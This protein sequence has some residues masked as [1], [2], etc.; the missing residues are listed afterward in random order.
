MK[1]ELFV[2]SDQIR[3]DQCLKYSQHS[4]LLVF[5]PRKKKLKSGHTSHH[6]PSGKGGASLI[7]R[8][9]WLCVTCIYGNVGGSTQAKTPWRM[10]MAGVSRMQLF[11]RLVWRLTSKSISFFRESCWFWNA[12]DRA[13]ITFI[14]SF[15]LCLLL[16]SLGLLLNRI[17]F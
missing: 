11:Y 9:A 17:F 10:V 14:L 16:L 3:W 4:T 2:V 5:F 1:W 7:F 13:W 12:L 6:F 15:L 8:V